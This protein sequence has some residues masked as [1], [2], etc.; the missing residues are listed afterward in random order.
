MN[1]TADDIFQ[2][3]TEEKMN[4]V[5]DGIDMIY[6][7]M[8]ENAEHPQLPEEIFRKQFL[9]LF[10][11]GVPDDVRPAL[12]TYW[13]GIAATPWNP[14]DIIDRQGQILFTVPSLY[15]R[16]VINT[17]DGDPSHSYGNIF[18]NYELQMSN[19]PIQAQRYFQNALEGKFTD[20]V[21]QSP[22]VTEEERIWTAIFQHYGLM[23]VSSLAE[24]NTIHNTA[25]DWDFGETLQD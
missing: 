19:I 17:K 1:M 23:K 4:R 24:D 11:T 3:Y 21:N 6:A 5:R 16:D 25:I 10:T 15:A 18:M 7:D 2:S 14:V 13:I 22:D 12:I 8:V 9:P 20:T